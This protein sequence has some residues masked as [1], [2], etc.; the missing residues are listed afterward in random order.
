[1]TFVLALFYIII[2]SFLILK[3]DFF[4]IESL[5]KK[6]LFGIF[7]LKLFAG[8]AWF[9]V[10]DVHYSDKRQTDLGAVRHDAS[11]IYELYQSN[12]KDALLISLGVSSDSIEKKYL[13]SSVAWFGNTKGFNK[14]IGNASETRD[15][16]SLRLITRINVFLSVLSFNQFSVHTFFFVILSYIGIILWIKALIN[17]GIEPILS[18]LAFCLPSFLF[19]NSGICKESLCVLAIGMIM[20]GLLNLKSYRSSWLIF[21]L[22][23]ILLYFLKNY[24]LLCVLL[25]M[26]IYLFFKH[27]NPLKVWVFSLLVIFFFLVLN[28]YGYLGISV[29]HY[30]VESQNTQIYLA[31]RT[32]ATSF[33]EVPKLYNNAASFFTMLPYALKNTLLMP[34]LMHIENFKVWPFLIENFIAVALFI[35]YLFSS[36]KQAN[37]HVRVLLLFTF[38]SLILIIGYNIPIL[39]SIVRLKAILFPYLFIF[40]LLPYQN[41]IKRNFALWLE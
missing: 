27:I 2:F 16:I 13:M 37:N 14:S 9:Y 35:T 4:K 25:P 18:M 23:S 3:L 20:Y 31:T 33:L 1:M 30:A 17:L 22:G 29:M 5:S 40:L 10:Y 6:V 39:G 19:W 11:L 34:N 28:L 12:I 8:F 21:V 15:P 32:L 38:M 41:T 26:L 24:L 36:N 7:A